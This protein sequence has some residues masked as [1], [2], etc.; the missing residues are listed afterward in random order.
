MLNTKKNFF[1][2]QNTGYLNYHISQ[3]RSVVTKALLMRSRLYE[4]EVMVA[5]NEAIDLFTL[6]TQKVFW[7]EDEKI[8]KLLKELE[9]L[10]KLVTTRPVKSC[11]VHQLDQIAK[12]AALHQEKREVWKTLSEIP[13]NEIED[14]FGVNWLFQVAEKI[15][16]KEL[17]SKNKIKKLGLS[18]NDRGIISLSEMKKIMK[19]FF[20][21]FFWKL[22]KKIKIIE[23]KNE[24]MRKL[25]WQN[26]GDQIYYLIKPSYELF[27]FLIYEL[28]H[29]LVHLFHLSKLA[30]GWKIY[31]DRPDQRAFFEA[32]ALS[33]EFVFHEKMLFDK[34]FVGWLYRC[35]DREKRPLVSQD[36]FRDSIV[37]HRE[38]EKKLRA[39]RLFSDRSWVW[40]RTISEAFHV[41]QKKI[42]LP[43]NL[44]LSELRKYE[45]QPWLW[46]CYSRGLH[47]LHALWLSHPSQILH[48]STPPST[49]SDFLKTNSPTQ[50]VIFW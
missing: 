23:E 44:L 14:I 37:A 13:P 27:D 42:K 34:K 16:A 49:R 40:K 31:R 43:K 21:K 45:T 39:I 15:I 10:K 33:G 29:N 18:K 47:Q 20:K 3:V 28:P 5:L 19:F 48:H 32:V 9:S 25:A 30:E 17:Y 4:K 41:L 26:M 11:F 50:K 38:K 24:E 12:I 7:N 22:P 2:L 36:Q 46:G 6:P 8:D 35:I 1:I